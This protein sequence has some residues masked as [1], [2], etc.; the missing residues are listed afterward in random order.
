MGTVGKI[1]V[2]YWVIGC[3]LA[4]LAMGYGA[5]CHPSKGD[6]PYADILTF[7]ATWPSVLTFGLVYHRPAEACDP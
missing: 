4:G 1:I 7:V 3:L 2:G 5:N 6:K